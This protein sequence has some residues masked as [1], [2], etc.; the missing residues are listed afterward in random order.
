MRYE[1]K[2][3]E[4][5]DANGN[6]WKLKTISNEKY[7]HK[8]ILFLCLNGQE[9]KVMNFVTARECEMF[10]SLLAKDYKGEIQEKKEEKAQN[11]E[12]AD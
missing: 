1:M 12:N 8:K 2:F 6:N 3:I 9:F 5:Q 11:A 10:W 4:A 7:P